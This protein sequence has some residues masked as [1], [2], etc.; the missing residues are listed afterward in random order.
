ME[1]TIPPPSTP[2]SINP[3]CA[4]KEYCLES[5]DPH[6][7]PPSAHRCRTCQL[8]LHPCCAGDVPPVEE[9]GNEHICAKCC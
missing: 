2:P 8:F 6:A 1:T 3:V 4:A 5:I 7:P 9:L